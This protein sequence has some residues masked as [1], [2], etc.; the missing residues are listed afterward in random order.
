MKIVPSTQLKTV[1]V[2]KLSNMSCL[3]YY[4][5]MW[6]MNMIPRGFN[7]NFWWGTVLG[8]G[9]EIIIK[10]KDPV[11]AEKA[12]L[13]I[14]KEE[15]KDQIIDSD[16]RAELDLQLQMI[17]RIVK[18]WHETHEDYI[19]RVTLTSAESRFRIKLSKSPVVFQGT[20]D[21]R[22]LDENKV[23]TMFELKSGSAQYINKDYFDRLKFDMQING[24]HAGARLEDGTLFR[25][26]HYLVFKKPLIRVK[27]TETPEQYL[28]RLW[29]DLHAR[30]DWYYIFFLHVFG[31][32]ST[33]DVLADI[34]AATFDLYQRYETLTTDE[35]LDPYNWPRNDS[36]CFRYGTCPYF[37]LCRDCT[38]FKLHS[39]MFKPRDIRYPLED[40]ELDE[41]RAFGGPETKLKMSKTAKSK[42]TKKVKAKR[43]KKQ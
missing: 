33:R 4:F 15:I 9:I 42:Y 6:V 37:R 23:P 3:R 12:M 25:H 34:E 29:D 13:K 26:C 7:V 41:N 32:Q 14:H 20:L 24:Y 21:G 5:W 43:G 31:K 38:K 10:T 2:H 28:D 17:I 40:E 1:C 19:S 8:E 11:K 18:A 39:K 27:Q 30:S 16:Q 35:L 36:Q 22:G